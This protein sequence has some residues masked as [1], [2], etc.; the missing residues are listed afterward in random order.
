M[1]RIRIL[2]LRIF[3]IDVKIE[4]M[5]VKNLLQNISGINVS[6]GQ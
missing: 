4:E 5:Y 1:F 6:K 3:V 2:Y